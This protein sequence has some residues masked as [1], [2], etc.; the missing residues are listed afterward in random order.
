MHHRTRLYHVTW[1]D[2]RGASGWSEVFLSEDVPS[3]REDQICGGSRHRRP[4]APP[5]DPRRAQRCVHIPA[6]AHKRPERCLMSGETPDNT[7]PPQQGC[8]PSPSLHL[9]E[10]HRHTEGQEL[11][12]AFHT[13]T[14]T[15]RLGGSF[16]HTL[17]I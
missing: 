9:S 17:N 6:S 15:C 14:H 2:E 11:V 8:D 4:Q 5:A 1:K 16:T 7:E 3:V 12:A 10:E 13:H